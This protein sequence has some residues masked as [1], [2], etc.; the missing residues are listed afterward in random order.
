[1]NSG[2]TTIKYN[3]KLNNQNPIETLISNQN[4]SFNKNEFDISDEF[5]P[6]K[7]TPSQQRKEFTIFN[8][9]QY[10]ERELVKK[11]IKEL[12][13][14]IRQEIKILK[15]SGEAIQSELK[16]I[17]QLTINSLPE[18]PG[19]YHIRFLEII[20]RILKSLREKVSESKTWLSALVSRKKKLGSLFL[21]LTKKKGTQYSL[22]QELSNARSVQ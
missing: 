13:E 10:Y 16:D 20:L 4:L 12:T 2:K 8:Y 1:M 17:E 22:S 15:K 6:S 9:S 7:K 18:K 3:A 14:Q 5:Q 21:N 11:Q 19:V